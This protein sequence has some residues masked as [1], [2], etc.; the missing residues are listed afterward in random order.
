MPELDG[1]RMSVLVNDEALTEYVHNKE[2]YVVG[3]ISPEV[4]YNVTL[5][6]GEVSTFNQRCMHVCMCVFVCLWACVCVYVLG[7]FISTKNT[8]CNKK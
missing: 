8:K 2:V 4:A 1:W 3:D 7:I 5:P 6:T